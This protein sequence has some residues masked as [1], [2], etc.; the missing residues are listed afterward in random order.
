MTVVQ[1]SASA[2]HD[3]ASGFRGAAP[4][5]RKFLWALRPPHFFCISILQGFPCYAYVEGGWFKT[6]NGL[7]ELAETMLFKLQCYFNTTLTKR[8]GSHVI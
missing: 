2:G 3:R 5:G 7:T 8:M 6:R 4:I 1:C